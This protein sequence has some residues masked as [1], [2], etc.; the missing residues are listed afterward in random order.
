MGRG[1]QEFLKRLFDITAAYA[2]ILVLSPVMLLIA[3]GVKITSKG[4]V[5]FRQKRLGKEGKPFTFLK[6]RSMYDNS[7]S[8]IHEEF[9]KEY[10]K[11][12]VGGKVFKLTKD[13]RVTPF[14]YIL[15]RTS[16]DELPQ[17]FNVLKGDMSI[18]GPRPPLPYEV[19]HYEEWHRE[20]LSVKPGITG[21]WQ[22]M[23]RSSVGFDELVRYDLEYI[24]K[25][26]FI[27]DVLIM[28]RTFWVVISMK[29]AY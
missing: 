15:R 6:F 29:G 7:E 4:P 28:F 26:N 2:L 1:D 10:I 25:H 23:G 14:G 13:P 11:G 24:R 17:L 21:L 20:R 3:L 18:V 9:V 5:F 12:G 22:V 16:L 8:G 19:E 27:F